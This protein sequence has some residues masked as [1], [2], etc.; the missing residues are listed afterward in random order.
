MKKAKSK[1]V[2]KKG[3]SF[4]EILKEA[5]KKAKNAKPMTQ[6]EMEEVNKLLGE[7]A[8]TQGPGDSLFV[9]SFFGRMK[10]GK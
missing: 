9:G 5:A 7:L 10:K 2:M 6:K 4:D 3:L 1:L 8:A